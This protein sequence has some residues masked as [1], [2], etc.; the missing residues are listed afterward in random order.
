M[1]PEM[2]R[3]IRPGGGSVT[4]RHCD[5]ACRYPRRFGGG[6]PL[7]HS[8]RHRQPGARLV[9]FPGERGSHQLW[10]WSGPIARWR[11]RRAS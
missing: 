10:V 9:W 8:S 5:R 11:I 7:R 1:M 3:L 2:N 6:L 4:C